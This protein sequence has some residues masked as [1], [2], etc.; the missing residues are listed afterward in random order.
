MFLKYWQPEMITQHILERNGVEPLN[1]YYYATHYPSVHA[2]AVRIWGT[3]K[4]AI[5]AC[6]LDYSQIRKYRIWSDERV[7]REIVELSKEHYPLASKFAQTKHKPLYMA[8]VRRFGSWSKALRKAGIDNKR[9]RLRKSRNP[10]EIKDEILALY[11]NNVSLSYPYMR[12][13]YSDL[14]AAGMKKLGD[15]SWQRARL[16]CGI[17][18]NYRAIGQASRAENAG[19]LLLFED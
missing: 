1:A 14:L 19:Q 9:V 10:E 3:W 17:D 8:A 11:R 4:D 16:A 15:G 13:H 7:V 2:A 18:D 5:E 12:E 6:G